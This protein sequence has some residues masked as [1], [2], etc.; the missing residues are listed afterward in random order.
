MS[1]VLFPDP[2]PEVPISYALFS[3]GLAQVALKVPLAFA[4]NAVAGAEGYRHLQK[5]HIRGM[6]GWR[7]R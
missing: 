3:C 7:G 5:R 4:T 1:I 6:L 2:K